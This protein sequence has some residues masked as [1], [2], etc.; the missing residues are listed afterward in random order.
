MSEKPKDYWSEC[1]QIF[2]HHGK[3]YGLTETLE[4]VCLGKEEDILKALETGELSVVGQFEI[5]EA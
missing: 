3:G 4:T 1:E 5:P 2:F